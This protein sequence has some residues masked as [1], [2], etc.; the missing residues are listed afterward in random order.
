MV[1]LKQSGAVLIVTLVALVVLTVMGI[2]AMGDLITQSSTV[3]NEQFRQRAFYAASSEL[4]AII[5]TVNSN[6]PTEDDFLIDG[7]LEN[8]V[9]INEYYIV[10]DTAEFPLQSST[11]DIT[12][13]NV[14]ISGRRNDLLGCNGES[15]GRVKVLSGVIDA[16]AR[17][18]DGKPSGG[19]RSRQQQRYVYCWP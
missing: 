1:Q 7:L 19:I 18:N 6:L 16:T 14:S 3:R 17:L 10:L 13:N 8:R 9:G 11:P 15:I 4:N 2:A 12:L 5:G